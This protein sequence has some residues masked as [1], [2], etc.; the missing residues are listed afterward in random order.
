M[1]QTLSEEISIEVESYIFQFLTKTLFPFQ[2]LQTTMTPRNGTK[3]SAKLS[4]G[5]CSKNSR[6]K[7]QLMKLILLM[8]LQQSTETRNSTSQRF[9]LHI[10]TLGSIFFLKSH[11]KF[12]NSVDRQWFPMERLLYS[13]W[14]VFPGFVWRSTVYF[15]HFQT[16]NWLR[17]QK[18]IRKIFVRYLV[19][20]QLK[21]NCTQFTLGMKLLP[22]FR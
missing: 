12:C 16:L 22:L 10:L 15:L 9:F 1:H 11:I 17:T 3:S 18:S 19:Q 20:V 21:K 5:L 8:T 7:T 2:I 4:I 6:Q 13:F 14:G